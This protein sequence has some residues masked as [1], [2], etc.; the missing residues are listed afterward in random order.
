M[1]KTIIR[2]P[3]E[4]MAAMDA[5]GETYVVCDLVTPYTVRRGPLDVLFHSDHW[6]NLRTA[7][8][9]AE[10]FWVNMRHVISLS[11]ADLS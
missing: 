8:E 7:T 2:S 11:V 9:P 10:Q 3:H 6:L 4:T 1:T 5:A